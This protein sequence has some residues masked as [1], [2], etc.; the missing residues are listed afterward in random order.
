M[1]NKEFPTRSIEEW[2]DQEL[3]EQYGFVTNALA[4][5]EAGNGDGDNQPKDVILEEIRRRGLQI[6]GG[7]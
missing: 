7:L 6:D 3:L 5:D 4:A 2:T 1:A